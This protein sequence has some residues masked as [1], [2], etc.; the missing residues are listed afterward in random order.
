MKKGESIREYF[1]MYED[2]GALFLLVYPLVNIPFVLIL[3][4][5][6]IYNKIGDFKK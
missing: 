6:V 2:T 1:D 4:F 3:I 5:H